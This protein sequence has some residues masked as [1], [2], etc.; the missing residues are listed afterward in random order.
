MKVDIE[1]VKEVIYKIFRNGNGKP[2]WG[3]IIMIELLNYEACILVKDIDADGKKRMS[4][5]E[6]LIRQLHND[7]LIEIS[8]TDYVN[9]IFLDYDFFPT[10]QFLRDYAISD[11]LE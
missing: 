2:M 3:R 1:K 7:G 9:S 8:N 11:L 10:K 6:K 4:N 5:Y